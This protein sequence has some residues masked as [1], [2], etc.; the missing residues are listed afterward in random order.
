MENGKLS[1]NTE[2]F[3]AQDS[4]LF[5]LQQRYSIFSPLLHAFASIEH[6]CGL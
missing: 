4:S 6:V 5:V 3:A 2:L 1:V